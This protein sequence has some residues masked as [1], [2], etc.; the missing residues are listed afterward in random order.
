MIRCHPRTS[1]RWRTEGFRLGSEEAGHG[2]TPAERSSPLR[3][4]IP[5]GVR[6][7]HRPAVVLISVINAGFRTAV[8][9]EGE[10]ASGHG[11]T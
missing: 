4:G 2:P 8:E 6:G 11:T 9:R 10:G 7:V 5:T 3:P 1:P